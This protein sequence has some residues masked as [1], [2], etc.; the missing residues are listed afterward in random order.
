LR[1]VVASRSVI[2]CTG[3]VSI[4]ISF[5]ENFELNVSQTQLRL[6]IG[7]RRVVSS[8]PQDPRQ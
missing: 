7:Y 6:P 4:R 2:M 5:K 1:T 3:D 8:E